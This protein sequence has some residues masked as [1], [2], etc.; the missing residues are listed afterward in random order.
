VGEVAPQ[1]LSECGVRL[2][3]VLGEP[4]ARRGLHGRIRVCG[5]DHLA[6]ERRACARREE[7]ADADLHEDRPE[8]A[9]V[10]VHVR[11]DDAADRLGHR[12]VI[13]AEIA[14]NG[15]EH[16][17]WVGREIVEDDHVH[18]LAREVLLQALEVLGVAAGR[19][20]DALLAGQLGGDDL[21]EA[22]FFTLAVVPVPVVRV[23]AV[24][25]VAHHRDELRVG[26][27]RSHALV[28]DVAGQVG[29]R[30]FADHRLAVRR[31]AVL[32]PAKSLLPVAREEVQ[33]LLGY[34]VDLGV[35]HQPARQ[36]TRAALGRADDHEVREHRRYL[37]LRHGGL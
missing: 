11:V 1:A 19:Q 5:A 3:E 34:H 20:V 24:D 26:N 25:R 2:G 9:R 36:R 23:R 7:L 30:C 29:G 14:A 33:L 4:G 32:V 27:V 37:S 6:V 12:R 8:P 22:A 13:D 10:V 35:V 16:R 21:L 15:T 28:C 31:E 17:V 18:A